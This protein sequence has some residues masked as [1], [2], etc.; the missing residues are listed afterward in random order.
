MYFVS[1]RPA[2]VHVSAR[3]ARSVDALAN[4]IVAGADV[5]D[6]VVG[7]RDGDRAD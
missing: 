4:Q 1:S 5:D 2:C 7:G 3:V 6:V